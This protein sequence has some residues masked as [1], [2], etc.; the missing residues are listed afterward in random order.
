[1]KRGSAVLVALEDAMNLSIVACLRGEVSKSGAAG[2]E[3]FGVA[4]A[5]FC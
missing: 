4:D 5:L 3:K 1:M 2:V